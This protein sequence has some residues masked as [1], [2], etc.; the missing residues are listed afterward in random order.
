M[1]QTKQASDL[2]YTKIAYT[3]KLLITRTQRFPRKVNWASQVKSMLNELRFYE[4]WLKQS[5]GNF[6]YF[7]SFQTASKRCI[8]RNWN[9]RLNDSSRALFYRNFNDFCFKPYSGIV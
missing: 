3:S 9:A 2:K 7:I 8:C 1:D 4:V 5:V 6:Q